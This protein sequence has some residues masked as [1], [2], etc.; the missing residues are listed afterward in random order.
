MRRLSVL[1]FLVC[2]SSGAWHY[3]EELAL[4]KVSQVNDLTISSNGELWVLSPSTISKVD[5][6]SGDLVVFK[7][8]D[9]ARAL[10]ALGPNLY[11]VDNSNRLV[12]Q[13]SDDRENAELTGL[14]LTNPTQMTA[15]SVSGAAGLIVLEP[16]R[17]VFA[18]PFE[19]ISTLST[20]AERFSIIPLAD[21]S[22]RRTPFFTLSGNRIFTWSGG[23]FLNAENYVSRL[24]YSA[25]NVVLDFCADKRGNLYILFADSITVLDN[26]GQYKGKIGVGNISRGSRILSNPTNNSLIVYDRSAKN[27]QVI[28]ET[29]QISEEL[30]VLDKNR[31]NPVDNYTEIPFTLSEPLFLTITIYNLIG[32]PVKQIARDR[33][34]RGSH[35]VAWKAD[36]EEGNLVPN[37]VYF[38]RLESNRGVAIRQLIV[39]R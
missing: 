27:I 1:I 26:N 18:T 38:Y 11:Y 24:I 28:A 25:S 7:H 22:D 36:D 16:T 21:Y 15:M 39:L 19:T 37:G 10:T 2:L 9:N 32:E 4:T 34:L 8:I 29:G 17:L 6:N 30:I 12:T 3:S 5:E 13:P 31:P 35:R 20:N 14:N 33:F 23:R